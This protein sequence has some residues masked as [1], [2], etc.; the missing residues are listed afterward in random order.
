MF[1]VFERVK[2]RFV[3][4]TF[5]SINPQ[6]IFRYNV[7]CIREHIQNKLFVDVFFD[8]EL[9]RIG[10]QFVKDPG[11]CSMK[12]C[13]SSEGLFLNGKSILEKL[14]IKIEQTTKFDL[15]EDANIIYLTWDKPNVNG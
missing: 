6:G 11:T 9:H 2:Q 14:N 7:K 1:E 8:K 4:K 10:F 12:L 15:K 3:P 13:K 5:V